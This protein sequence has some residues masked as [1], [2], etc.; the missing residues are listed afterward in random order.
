[1]WRKTQ[2]EYDILRKIAKHNYEVEMLNIK[3]TEIKE[4]KE[5]FKEYL[6]NN[7]TKIWFNLD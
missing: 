6:K 4:A 3:Y 5:L 2:T 1:M 7:Q